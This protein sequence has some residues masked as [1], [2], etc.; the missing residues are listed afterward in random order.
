MAVIIAPQGRRVPNNPV[1]AYHNLF[2]DTKSGVGRVILK[3]NGRIPV[4]PIYIHG[5]QEA[6]DL[7]TI[8]PKMKSY[9]SVSIC[10]PIQFKK[11][12]RDKGWSESDEDFYPTARKISLEIITSIRNQM[13]I[14]EKYLFQIITGLLNTSIEDLRISPDTHPQTYTLI[15][16]LSQYTPAELKQF[17]DQRSK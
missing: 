13:L 10:K 4:I 5:S 16:K 8:I 2:S 14:Q 12:Q 1:E 15:S 11:Y 7:G 17:I 3:H 6:L 9:I